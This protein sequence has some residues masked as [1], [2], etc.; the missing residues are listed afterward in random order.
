M[1]NARTNIFGI[2]NILVIF[3]VN[4]NKNNNLTAI[5]RNYSIKHY[6]SI[7]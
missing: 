4:P 2:N 3:N 7:R 6:T 5:F 1:D